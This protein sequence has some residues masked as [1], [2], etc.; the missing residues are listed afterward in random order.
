MNCSSRNENL[1]NVD[2]AN[3][4]LDSNVDAGLID[5]VVVYKIDRLTRSLPDFVRTVERFDAQEMSFVSVT[6]TFNTT[7]SMGRHTLLVNE[8]EAT[9]VRQSP[10]TR[11]QMHDYPFWQPLA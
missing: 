7:S 11:W 6:Q 4:A 3:A 2:F 9:T 10:K 1:A 5:V 8:Q